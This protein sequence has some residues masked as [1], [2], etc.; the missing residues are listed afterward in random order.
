MFT[1][2]TYSFPD[3]TETNGVFCPTDW[4]KFR[5]SCY[6]PYLS[7][8]YWDDALAYC[9][10][11]KGATL[12]SLNDKQEQDYVKYMMKSN[13]VDMFHRWPRTWLNL[14]KVGFMCEYE[15]GES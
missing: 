15:L 10:R 5:T 2:T 14:S 4:V 6:K 12:V 8:K 9:G 7:K 3:T 13:G 1:N 11:V